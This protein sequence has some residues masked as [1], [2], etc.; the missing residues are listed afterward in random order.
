MAGLHSLDQVV[1][2]HT[3]ALAHSQGHHKAEGHRKEAGHL[4]VLRTEVVAQTGVA[5]A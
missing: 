2:L 5:L 1:D 3:L 4:L